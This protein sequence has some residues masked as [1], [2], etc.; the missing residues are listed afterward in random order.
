MEK[1]EAH[2][3]CHFICCSFYIFKKKKQNKAEETIAMYIDLHKWSDA[4]RVAEQTKYPHLHRLRQDYFQY[5]LESNY[6]VK[7]E[8]T[9]KEQLRES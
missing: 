7:H 5:L 1:K 8:K 3:V 6:E 2:F 9:Q 4:L